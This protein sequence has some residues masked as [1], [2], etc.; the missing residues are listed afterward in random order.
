MQINRIGLER[1]SQVVKGSRI[2]TCTEI[3][4]MVFHR[5]IEV[6]I[7]AWGVVHQEAQG[8]IKITMYRVV[9]WGKVTARPTQNSWIIWLQR[10]KWDKIEW[11]SF[12]DRQ[13]LRRWRLGD[14][15]IPSTREKWLV[16]P[17]LDM[18]EIL[19]WEG[20]NRLWGRFHQDQGHRT[21]SD[22]IKRKVTPENSQGKVLA[23]A[24]R[25]SDSCSTWTTEARAPITQSKEEICH[26]CRNSSPWRAFCATEPLWEV[27]VR[28]E[29]A[30]ASTVTLIWLRSVGLE[31][32]LQVPRWDTSRDTPSSMKKPKW[33]KPSSIEWTTRERWK[34]SPELGK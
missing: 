10:I 9:L 1:V 16:R 12:Q 29:V 31:Q 13:I 23:A 18:S 27:R 3:L 28:A 5:L 8:F 22:R 15:L 20:L 17:P 6:A 33:E 32:A 7:R 2:R 25:V 24:R 26:R 34:R 4:E 11:R 21:T 19:S 14:P 30:R